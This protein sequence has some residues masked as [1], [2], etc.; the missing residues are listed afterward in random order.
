MPT[1]KLVLQE[2]QMELEDRSAL[3]IVFTPIHG[4]SITAVPQVLKK[5]GYQNVHIVKEQETPD[6]EF[7]YGTF[8]QSRRARGLKNGSSAGGDQKNADLM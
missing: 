4:T 5:A 3:Q 2:A 7:S 1:T 8:S 6:G